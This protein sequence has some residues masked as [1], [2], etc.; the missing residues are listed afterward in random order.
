VPR[1]FGNQVRPVSSTESWGSAKSAASTF[2]PLPRLAHVEPETAS[3][4]IAARRNQRRFI[5]ETVGTRCATASKPSKSESRF[6]FQVRLAR[7]PPFPT[8]LKPNPGRPQ[9]GRPQS[10]PAS[11]FCLDDRLSFGLSH[12]TQKQQDSTRPGDCRSATKSVSFKGPEIVTPS[13]N[14]FP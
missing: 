12:T 9:F 10:G 11:S 5:S 4:Q 7:L 8:E 6:R 1:T 2:E 13:K 14:V 3:F